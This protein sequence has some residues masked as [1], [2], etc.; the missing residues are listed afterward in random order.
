MTSPGLRTNILA[1]LSRPDFGLITALMPNFWPRLQPRVEASIL[2][3]A[4]VM[5]RML[6]PRTM[7]QAEAKFSPWLNTSI[8]VKASIWALR[9]RLRP[10]LYLSSRAKD[11]LDGK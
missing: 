10:K 6:R 3:S 2:A 4:K 7:L 11:G 8:S 9:P 5:T 1:S